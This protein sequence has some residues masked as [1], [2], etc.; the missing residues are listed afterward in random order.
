MKFTDILQ[1]ITVS[2]L[3]TYDLAFCCVLQI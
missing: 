1:I 3:R 2:Y